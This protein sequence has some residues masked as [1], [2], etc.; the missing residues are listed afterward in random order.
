MRVK[1]RAVTSA[2][3]IAIL[4]LVLVVAV[5]LVFTYFMGFLNIMPQGG[6]HL[7]VDGF[8][9]VQGGAGASGTLSLTAE[10]TGADPAVSITVSCPTAQFASADCGGFVMEINGALVS[11]ANPL[12]VKGTASGTATT[13]SAP[14]TAFTYA[15]IYSFTITATFSDGSTQSQ[16]KLLQPKPRG[17]VSS[18]QGD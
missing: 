7:V 14:G 6:N 8:F 1:L 11:S 18:S 17:Q 4:F 2:V 16:T 12:P 3:T 9:S 15:K 10:N 13:Q 5:L